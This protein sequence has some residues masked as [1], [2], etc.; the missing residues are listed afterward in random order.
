MNKKCVGYSKVSP[1][2]EILQVETTRR[3]KHLYLPVI[4]VM[5]A[6][7]STSAMVTFAFDMYFS[8]RENP[9]LELLISLEKWGFSCSLAVLIL[10]LLASFELSYKKAK[11]PEI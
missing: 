6:I 4:I 9:N 11:K 1:A 2:E 3:G 7:L 5:I 8:N 10:I